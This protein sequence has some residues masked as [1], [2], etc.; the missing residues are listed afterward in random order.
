M[1][2]L[3]NGS[4]E[5]EECRNEIRYAE[6]FNCSYCG[7]SLCDNCPL[8]HEDECFVSTKPWS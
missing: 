2:Q 5:C 4:I 8:S 7:A 6:E 3:L 1:S